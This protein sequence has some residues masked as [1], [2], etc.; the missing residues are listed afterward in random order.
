M[1]ISYASAI[2]LAVSALAS[3][4]A[5]AENHSNDP[6]YL[7]DPT[8]AIVSTKTRAQVLAELAEA[9]RTGDIVVN[10]GANGNS[11]KLNELYPERFPAKTVAQGKTRAQVLSEL[12][13]A[14][15]TGDIVVNVGANGNSKKLNELFPERYSSKTEVQ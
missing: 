9:Q 12:A 7:A 13:E 3:S 15:R 1:K 11:K 5:S 4:Y 6:G 10:V 8:S 14:Q 2:V